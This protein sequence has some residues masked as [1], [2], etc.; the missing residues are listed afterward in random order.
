M[1][2]IN[3][4]IQF[5]LENL[6]NPE[7][8]IAIVGDL[9]Y[10]YIYISPPLESGK[11]V[12]ISD[13]TRSLA[14]AAGYVASGLAKLGAKVHLLTQVGDDKDGKDLLKE[15]SPIIEGSATNNTPFSGF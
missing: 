9:N 15:I 6:S 13:F 3:D 12:L 5:E 7:P 8:K 4:Y 1:K 10:D 2:L 11:E 14:G